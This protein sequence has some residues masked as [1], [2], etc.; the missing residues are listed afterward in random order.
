MNS[1]TAPTSSTKKHHQPSEQEPE[2]LSHKFITNNQSPVF[3]EGIS[4]I[5]VGYPV[6][7]LIFS[8]QPPQKSED[9]KTINHFVAVEVI[10]PT[11]GLAELARQIV[12]SLSESQEQLDTIGSDW[13][14]NLSNII[15]DLKR[16]TS[17]NN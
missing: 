7:R 1:K 16:S 6:S 9:G 2:K 14:R 5:A 15:D 11:N 3:C 8:N 12:K 13:N 10:L 17:N 4:Q